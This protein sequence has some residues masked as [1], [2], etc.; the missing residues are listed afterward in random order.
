MASTILSSNHNVSTINFVAGMSDPGEMIACGYLPQLRRNSGENDADY[1]ARIT[2]L[3]AVLSQEDQ[4][5]IMGAAIRRANLDNS[6]GRV[7]VACVRVPAWHGLGVLVDGDPTTAEM[8]RHAGLDWAV[9]QWE[10]TAWNPADPDVQ[11][12]VASRR[13][14]V[15]S[16]TKAVLGVVGDGYTPL[17]N[18]EAFSFLDD[19]ARDGSAKWETAGAIDGGKR[20]WVMARMDSFDVVPGDEVKPY[21]LVFNGHDGTTAVRVMPTSVRV[22]CQNTANQAMSKGDCRKLT[23]RHSGSLKSRVDDARKCLGIVAKQTT[24]WRHEAEALT[25][26]SLRDTQVTE[27]FEQFFPRKVRPAANIDGANVLDMILNQSSQSREIVADLIEGH[28]AETER[29]ARQNAKILDQ[30]VSNFHNETNTMP[31]VEGTAYA[32]YNAVSEYADHQARHRTADSRLNS[33]W[34]GAGAELKAE[35]WQ[36]ALAFTAK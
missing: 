34:F 24:A 6:N 35:A 31:G 14:N 1:Q 2:P 18:A 28:F 22:V 13:A 19:L 7:A 11:V 20:V 8:I 25:R 17:Q 21:M 23:I 3:V 33:A 4:D 9:Q 32:A 12:D 10:L 27:Y 26:V 30:I 29:I 16:D 5:R 36:S 15:R